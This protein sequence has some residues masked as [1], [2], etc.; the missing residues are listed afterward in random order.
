MNFD[1]VKK[2]FDRKLWSVQM[3]RMAVV[4]KVIT[5]DQFAEITGEIY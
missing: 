4:R 1:M 3:V 5:A 2:N